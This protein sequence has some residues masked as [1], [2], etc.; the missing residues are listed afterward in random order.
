M[1]NYP[2]I[3]DI[4]FKDRLIK[5]K[6]LMNKNNLDLVVIFSNLLDPSA[7]RYFSDVSPINE[8]I[9]KLFRR[10]YLNPELFNH[11][12]FATWGGKRVPNQ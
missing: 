9:A 2:I 1:I 11:T 3:P 8:N 4:E 7:V 12:P 5:Y 6:E 10:E